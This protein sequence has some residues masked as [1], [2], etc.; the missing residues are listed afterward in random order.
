MVR[1][2]DN[3]PNSL[4]CAGWNL[5]PVLVRVF[6]VYDQ[7][8][9]DK[10]DILFALDDDDEALLQRFSRQVS[11]DCWTKAAFLGI[12]HLI[13]RMRKRSA[14]S[15]SESEVLQTVRTA[16]DAFERFPWRLTD[17]VEHAPELYQ[18]IA[19]DG[20]A[21]DG[22]SKRRFVSICREVAFER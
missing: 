7:G 2:C 20:D 6:E 18:E 21:G 9:T 22:I 14:G 11:P 10:F 12:A 17:L 1:S 19:S 16:R 4:E 15:L 8:T 5:H 3:C 13:S